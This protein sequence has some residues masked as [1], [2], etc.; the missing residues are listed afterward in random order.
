M[1][2]YGL[3]LFVIVAF[4][5]T[6]WTSAGHADLSSS[7]N[8]SAP[9]NAV[10]SAVATGPDVSSARWSD[11]KDYSFDQRAQLFVGLTLLEARVDG[12][13]RELNAKRAAMTSATD[14]KDWDF[15]MKEMNDARSF[16]ISVGDELRKATAETW[17]QQKET[18]GAAW[19]RT[20]E[21]YDKVKSSTT[22]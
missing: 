19:T 6:A 4:G 3:P 5:L 18:V 21:A 7:G 14:T 22:T 17:A 10:P 20:Q 2:I 9:P 11:I 13:I 15:A 1:K 12:Q 16:L 8:A